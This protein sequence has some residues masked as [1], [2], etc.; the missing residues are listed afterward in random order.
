M[1]VTW[2]PT[3]TTVYTEQTAT[4]VFKDDDVRAM[5]VDW[6]DG[7]SNKLE[8]ANFEWVQFTEPV[9]TGT[10]KHTYTASGTFNPVV[11]TINSKGIVSRFYA[12][13]DESANLTPFTQDATI[14]GTTISDGEATGIMR[15]ENKTVKSGID[16]SIFEKEGGKLLYLFAPPVITSGQLSS[17]N[18]VTVEVECIVDY[19]MVATRTAATIVGGAGSELV[20]LTGSLSST[21]LRDAA[22]MNALKLDGST[23]TGGLVSKVLKITY[24]NPKIDGGTTDYDTNDAFNYLKL[25][26]C[27]E[28]DDDDYYPIGYVS[29]GSPIKKANDPLR[30][31][32]LDFSQSRAAASN[33]SL[34]NYRYDNGKVFFNPAFQWAT[35]G[36]YFFD[37]NTVQTSTT[38]P[39]SYTYMT[40]PDGLNGQA[41]V[42]YT[43]FT[44]GAGSDWARDGV[45]TTTQ[46]YRTDQFII[47]DYG[48]FAPQYH[49]TRMSTEPSSASNSVDTEVSSI[50][51]N[52]PDVFRITPAGLSTMSN[53]TS[54]SFTKIDIAPVASGNYTADYTAA[55][56]QNG[57]SNLVSLSGAN[58]QTW[59]DIAGNTRNDTE[60]ILLLWDSKTNKVGFNIN[61]YANTLIGKT[62]SGSS[63]TEAERY[64]IAGVSYLAIDDKAV[65]GTDTSSKQH[66]YWKEVEFEDTTK[67]QLEL[68]NTSTYAYDTETNS[69]SQSGYVSFDMP[70]DW[71]SVKLEELCGGQ[72]DATTAEQSTDLLVTANSI[73]NVGATASAEF[74]GVLKVDTLT[75]ESL[76]VLGTADDIGAFKY[77]AICTDPGG[78]ANIDERPLWVASGTANGTNAALNDLYLTYGEDIGSDYA[79]TNLTSATNAK[80]LIRRVNIY[81]VITGVSKVER[82]GSSNVKLTPVDAEISAFPNKYIVSNT[83]SG[84]GSALKT[85]WSGSTKYAMRIAI[86]GS[87]TANG[88]GSGIKSFPEI[89][90]IFDATEGN[91]A[92]VKEID[93][94][95]YNLNSL[96]LTSGFSVSR[97]GNY[98]TAITRKGKVFIA[99]T[100]DTIQNVSLASVALGD[101]STSAASQFGATAPDSSYGH[102]HTIR[103]LHADTVRVYW[104]EP[105]K[106][107]TFVRFWGIITNVDENRP[108]G[109]PRSITSYS[110][111]M[112]VEEIALLE[113]DGKLMTDIFPLGG[114]LDE[115]D[116]T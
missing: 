39:V 59:N 4:F 30:T 77:I 47:D 70:L 81:D 32:T 79:P 67:A 21:D 42:V 60:Y 6:D 13:D 17:I 7:P 104:D 46:A 29:A 53:V 18:S 11:R 15:L 115:R 99:R 68:R 56:V 8:E 24:T 107:G 2:S 94:S 111:N 100:G 10:A 43:G 102:L 58:T 108:A 61:N 14:T 52:Q 34:K 97:A 51:A 37:D 48:R 113:N 89:W 25:F 50:I 12:N 90:N 75:G 44:T 103:K 106:D 45:A 78:V 76:S 64:K 22:G 57:S 109:G 26:I 35:T 110:C 80:F 116:F 41:S 87:G 83:S 84:V 86:K 114:V 95:A 96:P 19:S 62:L 72:F 69:L 74:G 112:T 63:V 71:E 9:A 91:V 31:V 93:D 49:L 54:G 36:S 23:F 88:A 33:I 65:Y 101:E 55:A 1:S 66:A 82:Q 40:R 73:T 20:T 5:Y 16:N 3:N 98:F 92:F 27:V 38:K 85:A 105:Q 28:G